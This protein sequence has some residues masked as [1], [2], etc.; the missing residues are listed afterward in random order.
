MEQT[1]FLSFPALLA[2]AF[3]G[4]ITHFLKKQIK[5]ETITEI[6]NY[7]RDHIKSTI[8]AIIVTFVGFMGYYFTLASGTMGDIITV[9]G[10]GYMFD[11]M[12]NKYEA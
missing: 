8:L 11:S 7:F 9:F 12:L 2:I 3:L 5:G 6:K 4:M 1:I 10:I